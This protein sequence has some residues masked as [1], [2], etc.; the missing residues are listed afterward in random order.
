MLALRRLDISWTLIHPK[1]PTQN[2][3]AHCQRSLQPEIR[4]LTPIPT[5]QHFVP[6]SRTSYIPFRFRQHPSS[7]FSQPN[8]PPTLPQKAFHP[9]RPSPP[10]PPQRLRLNRA[11]N[12]TASPRFVNPQQRSSSSS[13]A[14]PLTP[15][16]T[17]PLRLN[18]RLSEGARIL[19]SV[20]DSASPCASNIRPRSDGHAQSRACRA[21]AD[22]QRHLRIHARRLPRRH[23]RCA[24]RAR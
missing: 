18:V 2:T 13:P 5:R 7:S 19:T 14:T 24:L 8:Q 21:E 6:V 17:H 12:H 3:C 15:R 1:A 10:S 9:R 16:T 23:R 4:A 11:A 22:A 20:F